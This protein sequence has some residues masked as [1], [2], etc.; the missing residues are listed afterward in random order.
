MYTVR[1]G[2]LSLYFIWT[3]SGELRVYSL[4]ALFRAA[5]FVALSEFKSNRESPF[6]G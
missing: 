4:T 5:I 6:A 2:L 1:R 3:E